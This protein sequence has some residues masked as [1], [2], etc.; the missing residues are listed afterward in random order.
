MKVTQ[1]PLS[2]PLGHILTSHVLGQNIYFHLNHPIRYVCLTGV[3]VS[4]E[5]RLNKY[6]LL[7]LDDGSGA[8]IT[9]KISRL[10]AEVAGAATC[11][12]NT[13]VSNVDVLSTLGRY[14]VLVDKVPLDI[15]TILKVKCTIS[16]FRNV[17]QLELVRIWILRSTA[18]EIKEWEDS[19]KFKAEVLSKPWLLSEEQLRDF[20]EAEMKKRRNKEEAEKVEEQRQR[21][22]AAKKLKRVERRREHEIRKEARRRKEDEIMNAGA[23]I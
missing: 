19:A 18:E 15:G 22:E 3:L 20:Q 23:I 12:S 9:L 5:D 21:Q 1:A 7:D 14:N 13:T 10:V 4:I 6:T 8:I 2:R 16:V 11:P 17:R